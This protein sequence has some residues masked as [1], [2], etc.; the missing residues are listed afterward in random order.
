[1]AIQWNHLD[2]SQHLPRLRLYALQWI[3]L[4]PRF[5]LMFIFLLIRHVQK[6][7][8]LQTLADAAL[9]PHTDQDME[10]KHDDKDN[11]C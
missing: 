5:G 1:M 7:N 6:R 11:V 4:V 2:T 3:A 8:Q 10:N 9:Q